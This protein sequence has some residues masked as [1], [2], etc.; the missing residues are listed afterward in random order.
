MH[1]Q[2]SRHPAQSPGKESCAVIRTG[3]HPSFGARRGGIFTRGQIR[4]GDLLWQWERFSPR[5]GVRSASRIPAAKGESQWS[6]SFRIAACVARWCDAPCPAAAPPRT[7][8]RTE[9]AK[10]PRPVL[11]PATS[12][13]ACHIW[14]SGTSATAA[15]VSAAATSSAGPAF[16]RGCG[17]ADVDRDGW[18]HALP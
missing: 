4:D 10:T 11:R 16:A 5:T 17:F 1:A 9:S 13:A 6:A 14:H 2:R 18:H 3:T 8:R 7:K 12:P 15:A